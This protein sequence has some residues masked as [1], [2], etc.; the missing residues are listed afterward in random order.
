MQQFDD[1]LASNEDSTGVFSTKHFAIFRFCPEKSCDPD[2]VVQKEENV[3]E[4]GEEEEKWYRNMDF[5]TYQ[6]FRSEKYE[7]Y[8][9]GDSETAR[10]AADQFKSIEGQFEVGGAGGSGCSSNYG[11]YMIE[12]EGEFIGDYMFDEDCVLFI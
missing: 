2:A 5:A 8:Q 9:Y 11:E 3:N 1:N 4:Y 7:Q 12:L 6:S 10:A